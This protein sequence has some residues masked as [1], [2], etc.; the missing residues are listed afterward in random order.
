MLSFVSTGKVYIHCRQG[1]SRSATIAIAYLMIK[2][3][4]TVQEAVRR[5]RRN[6]EILPNEGFL[7]QLCIL[8]QS[9]IES[10]KHNS[11]KVN[12]DENMNEIKVK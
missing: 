12:L 2:K 9:L 1:I 4:L 7:K 10:R 5:I 11:R 8:N 3:D 6:R